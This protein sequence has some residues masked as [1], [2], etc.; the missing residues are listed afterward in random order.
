MKPLALLI[1]LVVIVIGVVGVI[2]PDMLVAAADY[3][4]TPGGLLMIA[5]FRVAVGIVL[6]LVAS[7]TRAPKVVRVLGAV[8]L[9]AGLMT[10]L[11]GVE[12]SR[13]VMAW[14]TSYGNAPIRAGAALAVVLGGFLAFAVAAGRRRA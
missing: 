14:E 9:V 13:A 2:R 7:A 8:A 5:A 12:R 3:V 10:P 6:L 11:F 4:L 1:A